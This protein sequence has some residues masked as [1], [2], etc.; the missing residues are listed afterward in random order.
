MSLS[1]QANILKLSFLSAFLFVHIEVMAFVPPSNNLLSNG[2][3]A[4]A[5]PMDPITIDGN[6][7][8]WPTTL[9]KHPIAITPY[10]ELPKKEDFSA[11]FQVGHNLNEKAL[12]VL[13]TVIDDNHVVD[14]SE[15]ATWITQD[16][17]ALYVD[18]KHDWNGSGVNL[19]QFGESFKRDYDY[20]ASWDPEI[21]HFNWDNVTIK[22]S[23]NGSTSIY[24]VK[25]DLGDYFQLNKSIG[26]DHVLVDKDPEDEDGTFTFISWGANGGK[27]QSATRLGDVIP[28]AENSKVSEVSGKLSWEDTTIEEL[29]D[30]VTL[31]DKNNSKLWSVANVDTLG[32]FTTM[33]PSGRYLAKPYWDFIGGYPVDIENSKAFFEV[34]PNKANQNIDLIVKTKTPL[35]LIPKKGILENFDPNNPKALDNFITAYQDYYV[36]PGVSLAIIKDGKVVYHK[37]YGNKNAVTREAVNSQTLFEAASITKPVFAFAVCRLAEKGIIDLD[38]PL[39]TYLPFEDIAHDERYKLIT[40][41]H[42]LTHQTGFPNWA[43]VNEDGK[44][45]IKFTPGTDYG[46]SGE[47]FEYLKR[48][49][50]K[51]TGKDVEDVVKEEVLDPLGMKNTYF[52]KNDYMRTHV[53]N[54]HFGRFASPAN[55]PNEPGMAW[56]MHTEAKDFSN[57]AL[58]LLERK[59]LK[60]ETYE[61]VFKT[62]TV[63]DDDD[64]KESWE[65]YFGLGISIEKTPFGPTFGHGGNNGDFRCQFKLFTQL[66]SGFIIFTNSNHG[67]DLVNALEEYLITGKQH[68][69]D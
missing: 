50:N 32:H 33:L 28:I 65:R 69:N 40:A 58:G 63:V 41:R 9:E 57:F 45:D 49:V 61:D 31:V 36:I 18:Y 30:R 37:T 27:S 24:E 46:Y 42:V 47:G 26:I 68:T 67:D 11:Y 10:G 51:I 55:L 21:K 7:K 35:N 14:N 8:D 20:T 64:I 4:Y 43:W 56:S 29:P 39:Y 44:I 23:R 12:Y 19:F 5:Y 48:V 54:G 3:L 52:T 2:A 66:N 1:L 62:H 15:N 17:Y 6:A 53:S 16:S 59:V 13:I 60:P 38:K 34:K 22:M 25:I